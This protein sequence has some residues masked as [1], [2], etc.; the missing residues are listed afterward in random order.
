MEKLRTVSREF[1]LDIAHAAVSRRPPLSFCTIVARNEGYTYVAKV[2]ALFIDVQGHFFL[3]RRADVS[4]T[5]RNFV[6]R[7]A[8][9]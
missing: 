9:R 7:T 4:V 2:W 1:G 8:T 6:S 3:S 5:I